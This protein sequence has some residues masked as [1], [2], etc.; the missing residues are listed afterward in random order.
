MRKDIWKSERRSQKMVDTSPSHL[1]FTPS[2]STNFLANK[3]WDVD[4]L[5][6]F[7][8]PAGKEN[9]VKN[10]SVCTFEHVPS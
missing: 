4:T 2:F 1:L 5:L 10:I 8:A 7:S 6:C 9:P 3:L